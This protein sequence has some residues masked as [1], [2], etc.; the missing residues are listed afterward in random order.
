VRGLLD[1]AAARVTGLLAEVGLWKRRAATAQA[2]TDDLREL[3]RPD[4]ELGTRAAR[5]GPGVRD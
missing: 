2:G 5:P 3:L 1:Q 4:P